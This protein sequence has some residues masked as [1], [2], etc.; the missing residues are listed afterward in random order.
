[1]LVI[2]VITTMPA[3]TPAHSQIPRFFRFFRYIYG[4]F[5]MQFKL[6]LS[7]IIITIAKESCNWIE[8][9]FCGAMPDDANDLLDWPLG[10]L[11]WSI[12]HSLFIPYRSSSIRSSA[13]LVFILCCHIVCRNK[14]TGIQWIPVIIEFLSA[15]WCTQNLP[16]IITFS[17][18][19][20]H[21]SF[22]L[23]FVT[24]MLL[25]EWGKN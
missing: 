18:S 16:H 6:V 25:F 21:T 22:H 14:L 24:C 1:M 19:H 7:N 15:S 5:V 20:F 11:I 10:T 8:S 12:C 3:P 9:Y 2:A 13:Q 17:I 4:S 23:L